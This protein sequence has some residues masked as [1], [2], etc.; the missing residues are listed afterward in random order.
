MHLSVEQKSCGV[1][2]NQI[3]LVVY[4]WKQCDNQNLLRSSMIAMVVLCPKM[5]APTTTVVTPQTDKITLRRKTRDIKRTI[6][7]FKML[8]YNNI[9]VPPN[10]STNG[11]LTDLPFLPAISTLKIT[12]SY[13]LSFFLG[14]RHLNGDDWLEQ[15]VA[16]WWRVFVWPATAFYVNLFINLLKFPN[17]FLDIFQRKNHFGTYFKEKVNSLARNSNIQTHKIRIH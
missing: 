3:F 1:K 9:D 17:T 4:W 8:L 5:K 2:V 7:S 11:G 15:I 12:F 6:K 16:D 13:L 14:R 10:L